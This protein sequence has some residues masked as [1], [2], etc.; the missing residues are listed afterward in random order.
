MD[1]QI[2]GVAIA[3]GLS[4]IIDYT[5]IRVIMAYQKQLQASRISWFDTRN[6]DYKETIFYLKMTYPFIFIGLLDSITVQQAI[7]ATGFFSTD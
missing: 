5:L 7:I 3:G 2:E 1:M 4:Y 6:F